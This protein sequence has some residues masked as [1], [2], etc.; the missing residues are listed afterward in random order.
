V[1][2]N[3]NEP[4][5]EDD[6]ISDPSQ[7]EEAYCEREQVDSVSASQWCM[8]S[9]PLFGYCNVKS[10]IFLVY[11][12]EQLVTPTIHEPASEF[13]LISDPS[14]VADGFVEHEHSSMNEN[15]TESITAPQSY[16]Y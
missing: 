12:P 4:A 5:S 6:S 1:T 3:V 13:V 9:L 16:L 14:L 15:S 11:S 8:T 7:V 10:R 2:P